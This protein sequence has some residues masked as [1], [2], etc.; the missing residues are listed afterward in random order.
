MTLDNTIDI[1]MWV[2]QPILGPFLLRYTVHIEVYQFESEEL[3]FQQ[4]KDKLI[5]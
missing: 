5:I 3:H 1:D 4:N 2:K